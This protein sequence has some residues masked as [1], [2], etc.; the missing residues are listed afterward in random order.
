MTTNLPSLTHADI[1]RW[2]GSASFQKG[3]PYF[4]RGAIF[5]PRRQGQTLKARCRG[6]QAASYQLQATLGPAGIA[7]ADCSCPVGAGGRCK[8]VAALLLTWLDIPDSF[9][10][11]EDLAAVLEQRSKTELIAL[12][13]QMI[14]REPDLEILLEMPLPGVETGEKPLDPQVIRRQAEHAFRSPRGDWEMG[15]GDPYEIVEELQSLFDLA[16]QY[17][18]QNNPVNAATIYRMV[19]ETV[20]DN[21]DAVVQDEDGRLGGVIDDCAEGL[22]ECLESIT[23]AAQRESILK[24]LFDIYAWDLKMGGIGIGDSAPGILLERATPQERQMISDWIESALTGV[25]EWSRRAMGGLLLIL[26][27]DTMDDETFLEVCRQTGRLK[28]LVNRLLT[29]GRVDEAAGEARQAGDYDLL[30]LAD[31]FVQHGH[32]PLA[33]KLIRARSETS[34][35]TRLI[36]WLKAYAKEQG[37]LTEALAL[38]EKLFWLR[39]SAAA[40]VEM[41]QLAQPQQQ[42]PDLRAKT[43]ASLAQKGEHALLTQI[44]LEECEIDRALESLERAKASSRYWGGVSLQ[45]E[46]AEAAGEKRPKES[47]RLYMQLVESL[48]RQRGRDG[49]AQAAAHLKQVRDAYHRLD[50]PQAWQALIANIREQHRNLPALRDELNRAGL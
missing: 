47:I 17:E 18:A 45:V 40:Y 38:A 36:E 31:L 4:S 20:L 30:N 16:K 35:D 19:A 12:I 34:K 6:S 15:W 46:V 50:E 26:Q 42:W 23:E 32:G 49:Y 2:A 9:Q 29:L 41:R 39:P 22:G 48:I 3:M 1:Q 21:E 24:A 43:L 13:R 10:E 25:G 14:Q 28:D 11:I 5:D 7:S 33:E 8:H 37:D 27:A 44:Y